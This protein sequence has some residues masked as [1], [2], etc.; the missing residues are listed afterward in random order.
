MVAKTLVDSDIDAGRRL[1]DKLDQANVPLRAALWL[2]DADFDGYRLLLS[3]PVYDQAGPSQAYQV[4]VN[5]INTLS[6]EDQSRL[7]GIN[8]VGLSDELVNS[9][10]RSVRLN[11]GVKGIRYSGSSGREYVDDAWIYRL[12]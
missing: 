8:I 7:T 12:N 4:V 3:T 10:C 11:P 6:Q 5:T 9:L 2:F 1:I